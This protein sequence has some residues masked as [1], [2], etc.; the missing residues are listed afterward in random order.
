MADHGGSVERAGADEETFIVPLCAVFRKHLRADRQKF[1]PERAQVL[2]TVIQIDRVF[3]A[4]ELLLELRRRGMAVSKA[5][6][7]RTLK[8]LQDAGIIEAVV[9]DPPRPQSHYRLAYGRP[10]RDQMICV[11]TGQVVE[12]SAPELK[13]LRDRIAAEH[14]WSPVGHRFQIFAVSGEASA[15]A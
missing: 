2:D 8:L 9:L 3:E 6:V 14:G 10:P 5:T 1:T 4:D 12:F 7:Y 11:E 15:E 13:Q